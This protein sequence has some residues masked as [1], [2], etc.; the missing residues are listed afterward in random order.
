MGRIGIIG[1]M[2]E[3]VLALREKLKV[4]E[5]RSIASLEFYVG[6]LDGKEVVLVRAGIGKVNA[7]ICTQLMI[8][9]FNVDAIVNTGVAG[10]L[11]ED[12][13]IG[14]I[15]ISVDSLQHDVDATGFG[16]AP[17][18]IPRMTESIFKADKQ[19]IHIAQKASEVL[20]IKT[21]VY[22]ERIVSGDQ[23]ISNPVIK[24]RLREEF[25]GFCVEM[26]GAAI[27]H[28]CVLN[29][30]PYVIIRAISDTADDS[31]EMNFAEFSRMAAENSCMMLEKMLELL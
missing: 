18:V 12:L 2:E 22:T 4:T 25:G 3:E 21:N 28:T 31:A 20:N 16:Y 30:V 23:F 27:A 26:E 29:K 11:S 7:A 17:G 13:S 24:T 8:D 9:C 10:A 1:A 19:L 6:F 14:D 5:V 15:V